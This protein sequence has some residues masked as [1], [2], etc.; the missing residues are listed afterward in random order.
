IHAQGG[1]VYIP[2]PF[3]TMR[4]GLSYETLQGIAKHVD[5][6][7][8]HNGRAIFQNFSGQAT[9]WALEHGVPGASSSDA[10]GVAGW[11]RTYTVIGKTPT[12]KN[13]VGQLQKAA[14]AHRFPGLHGMLYPK[15]NRW[16]KR[17]DKNA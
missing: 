15:I 10:H 7:E 14:Y 9:A 17:R 6:M 12:R 1:L 16:Q 13:L 4:K 3:E 8:V 2:H 11:G 5:I